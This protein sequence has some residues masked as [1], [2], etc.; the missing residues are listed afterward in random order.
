MP[1]HHRDPF[2][3]LRVAQAQLLDLPIAT[4]DA[5]LDRY[6]VTRLW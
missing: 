1:L 6:E 5:E 2:D 4:A 3:R